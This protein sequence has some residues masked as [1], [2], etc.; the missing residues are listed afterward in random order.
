M[1]QFE[2][3]SLIFSKYNTIVYINNKS[4]NIAT[5]YDYTRFRALNRVS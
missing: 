1:V 4:V 2:I 3:N 5:R